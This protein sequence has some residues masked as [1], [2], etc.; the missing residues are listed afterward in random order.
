MI[1]QIFLVTAILISGSLATQAQIDFKKA[2]KSNTWLKL[3]L[4]TALPISSLG[5]TQNF[6]IG[7]DASIQFLETKASGVGVKVGYINYFGKGNNDNVG[8]LPVAVMLRY[9]P[10]SVGWFAGLE[11]GYAFVNGLDRTDGGY[12]VRPQ[13]GLHYDYWNFFGYYDTILVQEVGGSNLNALGLGV[14]YNLHFK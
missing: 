11:L 5:K 8:V 12:F 2:N 13:V 1:K 6:G 10:E 3:G 7:V 9:Y 4:N 14:T